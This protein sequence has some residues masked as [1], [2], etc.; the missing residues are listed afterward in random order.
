MVSHV[1]WTNQCSKYL[2]ADYDAGIKPFI[3]LFVV[4]YF[5]DILIYSR[6]CED[7]EEHLKQVMCTLRVEKFILI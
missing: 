4:V 1:V 2:H 6:S 7:H 5:D 3:G